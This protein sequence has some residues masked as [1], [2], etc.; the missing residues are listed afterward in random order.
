MEPLL[1]HERSG[2]VQMLRVQFKNRKQ[3]RIQFRKLPKG[4]LKHILQRM[5][6]N[7]KKPMLN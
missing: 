4:M 5:P 3:Q 2:T 1:P 7:F 6:L